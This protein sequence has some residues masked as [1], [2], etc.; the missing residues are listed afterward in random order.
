M[1]GLRYLRQA[2]SGAGPLLSGDVQSLGRADRTTQRFTN[3]WNFS[4][5][6]AIR[7]IEK[8]NY[9]PPRYLRG[10]FERG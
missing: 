3:A 5:G 1:R 6:I 10:R 7:K 4:E 9:R 2:K 8:R